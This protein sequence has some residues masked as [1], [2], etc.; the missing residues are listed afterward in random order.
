MGLREQKKQRTREM[1]LEH[2]MTLFTEKGVANVGMRELAQVCGLGIGT[3]YN[4]F[5]SKE[6]VL[7]SL[8]YDI[9]KDGLESNQFNVTDGVDQ[10]DILSNNYNYLYETLL[11]HKNILN[12]FLVVALA[13]KNYE[14]DDS[15]GVKIMPLMVKDYWKWVETFLDSAGASYSDEE[16]SLVVAMMWHHFLTALHVLMTVHDREKA[17]QINRYSSRHLVKGFGS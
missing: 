17:A 6:E 7:F 1:I 4:Y 12:E 8:F 15:L 13:P 5:H 16:E 11:K 2:S 10:G 9:L 14:S 3:Y